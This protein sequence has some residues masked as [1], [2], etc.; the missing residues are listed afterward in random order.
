[1]H[2]RDDLALGD[3]IEAV[4]RGSR[5]TYGRPRIR[6]ELKEDGI[7]VSAKRIAQLM[8]ERR[9][10]GAS[11]RKTTVTTIRNRDARPAPDPVGNWPGT[12]V[13]F[14]CNMSP[15]SLL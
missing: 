15:I 13:I 2:R 9:I 1:V 12:P 11:R 10:N 4:H 8:R 3:R 7:A 6:A 5:E 14:G